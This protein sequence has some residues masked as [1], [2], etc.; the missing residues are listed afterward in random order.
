MPLDWA[1]ICRHD[2]E[3][4]NLRIAAIGARSSMRTLSLVESTQVAVGS[5]ALERCLQ[6][7]LVYEPELAGLSGQ[8]W[9]L[10]AGAGMHSLVAAPLRGESQ[11]FGIL[12]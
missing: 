11:V 2:A 7:E 5:N 3:A 4:G 6:G 8:F 9:Q 1:C 12:A 10:L